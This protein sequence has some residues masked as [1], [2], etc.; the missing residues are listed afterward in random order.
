[1]KYYVEI[2]GVKST[3]IQGLEIQALPNISKPL[4]R[5]KRET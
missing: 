1:M 4:M 3:T 2:N 5:S